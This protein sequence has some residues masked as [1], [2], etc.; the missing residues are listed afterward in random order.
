MRITLYQP[1][2]PQNTGTIL[3]MAACMDVGVDIIEPCGFVLDDKRLRRSGMDYLDQVDLTRH[4]S[5]THFHKD[6]ADAGDR[7]IL[8]TTSGD[9]PYCDF[10]FQPNDRLLLGRESAGAPPEVHEAAQARLCIPMA[11]GTRSLNIAMATS[12]V[13]G[14][15]LRQTNQFATGN[16]E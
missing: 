13:L 9:L 5:W 1:D 12:M 16:T 3:R 2:I 4:V 7:L 11:N 10:A 6:C 15:A 14:E 8:L